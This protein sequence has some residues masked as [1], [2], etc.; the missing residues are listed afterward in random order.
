M[1][2][3]PL[4]IRRSATTD[5]A[6]IFTPVAIDALHAVAPLDEDRQAV[7]RGRLS[8]RADR[9]PGAVGRD[10]AHDH[11]GGGC[12]RGP[13]HG[14]CHSRRPAAPV[15]SGHGPAARPRATVEQSIRNVAYALLSSADG[16]R[17]EGEDALR[18]LHSMSLDNQ[19]NLKLAIHQ[20]PV[21]LRAAERVGR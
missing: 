12:S 11:P 19:R 14:Q 10:R 7:M 3:S 2:F 17:F 5:Y 1:P 8:R 16:W 15:D 4:E 9:L 13:L 20:D 6:D 18:Q 21:F